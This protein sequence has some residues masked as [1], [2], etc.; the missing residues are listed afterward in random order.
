MALVVETVTA[1][2]M[3]D[4]I[5]ARDAVTVA[6]MVELRLDGV[7]DVDVSGALSGRTLPVVVTC[8]A[9][10][11]G[12]RFDGAEEQRLRLLAEACV[13]GAEFVDVEWRADRRA[14]PA[15]YRRRLV[16]S[17]HEFGAVPADLADRVRAMRAESAGLIKVAVTAQR[18]GDCQTLRSAVRGSGAY[19]AIAMGSAGRLTRVWPAW[20]GSCWMY[21]GSA[22]SGQVSARDLVETYR[23]Q[24]TTVN[25]M[26]FGIVGA[27]LGH[28]ASPAMHNAAF[29]ALGIDA[30]YVP[31]E[32]ADV[33]E[34]LT[35]ADAVGLEGASITAPLK[36]ALAGRC[37]STDETTA[38]VGAV[39]TLKRDGRGW[40][41]R[42]FD[43]DGFLAPL[44][45]LGAGT[46]GSRA[47]VLGAGG[48]ARSAAWALRRRGV[49]V[50]L[51]ARRPDA[52][53]EAAGAV[54][55]DTTAWPAAFATTRRPDLLVNATPV[56]AWPAI[57]AS[58]VETPDARVV[59][60]LVY[61][62]V[63]TTLL[64]RARAAGARTIG[65]LEMLVE[66]AARQF[67][68]WTEQAVPRP[69]LEQAARQF[70]GTLHS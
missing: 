31:L 33:E 11:E 23:V 38:A 8:R 42:N 46:P 6:D 47:T 44:D 43:V 65:G 20:S 49:E 63:E 29:A 26:A 19:V 12:G 16:L 62:P 24:Q 39:N 32:T 57:E 55:V 36:R 28:S 9:A 22:A 15:E 45:R 58:P 2:S 1:D 50:A 52:A 41:G 34:F 60:D 40:A 64:R 67:E 17:H 68:W 51:A 13:G 3:A 14:I 70:L 27:P 5:A 10:W 30:V 53:R 37:G 35:M 21:A 54:G 69:L 48:A 7:R 66:Q 18:L 4:L 56:G 61:N 25:S 59:Y